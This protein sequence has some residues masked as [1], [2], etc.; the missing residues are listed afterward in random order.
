MKSLLHDRCK[1]VI[2]GGFGFIGSN[3]AT[4]LCDNHDVLL[5]SRSE[6]K[7]QNISDIKDK[8][9]YII[10]SDLGQ[11]GLYDGADYVFHCA[12]T[13]SNYHL[14]DGP[15]EDIQINCIQTANLLEEIRRSNLT[16]KIVYFS[17]FFV[18]GDPPYLPV[19]EVTKE[20]P[21][22]T[23]GS[24]KLCC[25]NICKSYYNVF[26][27]RSVIVRLSNI[28]GIK[29]QTNNNKKAALNRMISLAMN[30]QPINLYDGGIIVRDY[31]Y[32]EDA[33]DASICAAEYGVSGELYCVGSG[34]PQKLIDLI[35]TIIKTCNGG[36]INNIE[37]TSFHKSC[38]IG[39]FY[40]DISKIKS[41]G[42]SP[43]ISF[44]EGVRKVAEYK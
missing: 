7:L 4:K 13:N 6:L 29:E 33:V 19:S 11:N 23:Y 3:L 38:G 17:T 37:S 5:I 1:V 22:G 35:N 26:G 27:I 36:T 41:L 42:W 9:K 12:S 28:Y 2:T 43:K 14:L 34:K 15:Y 44:E 30:N 32:V 25:E 39:N 10:T 16:T 8:V 20:Y 40:F 18:N 31:L 24:T 21:K